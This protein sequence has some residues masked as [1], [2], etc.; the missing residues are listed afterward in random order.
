MARIHIDL[1]SEN[2]CCVCGGVMLVD[3]TEIDRAG[4][5]VRVCSA[6]GRMEEKDAG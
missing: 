3:I 6:C 5:D 4:N 2:V 1:D